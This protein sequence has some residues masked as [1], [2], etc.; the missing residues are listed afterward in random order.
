M[1][2][3]EIDMGLTSTS[4]LRRRDL[5]AWLGAASVLPPAAAAAKHDAPALL[6]AR[7]ADPAIDPAGY[8]VSEKFDGVRAF[9]DGATLHFRSGIEVAAPAWF[10]QRLPK[11]PLDGELWL[12]RGRFEALSGIVRR[13]V[14]DA[15]QWREVR[16]LVFELP[17]AAGDFTA[18]AAQIEA[19]VSKAAWPQ[20]QAVEQLRIA[21]RAALQRRFDTVVNAGGEGLVLHRADAPYLTGR[22]DALLKLKPLQDAEAVVIGHVAGRGKHAGRLG[23]LRVQRDDG[24]VFQLGT[25]FSDA[26]RESPPPLGCTVTYTYRGTTRDGVPRFASFLRARPDA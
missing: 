8:L 3:T 20:L 10:L 2:H 21:D 22:G 5:L 9:W 25:G 11:R 16:Y 15:G 23:A 6:L 24:L 26:Q 1:F 17:G 12:G 13:E 19:A 18:R 4:G 7:E 14:P